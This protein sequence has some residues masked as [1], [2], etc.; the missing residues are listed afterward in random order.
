MFCLSGL[1]GSGVCI[2]CPNSGPPQHLPVVRMTRVL[3]KLPQMTMALMMMLMMVM[4]MTM[5]MM[6]MMMLVVVVVVLVVVVV[7]AVV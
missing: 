3:S 7:V 4:T 1:S 5:T 2:I 6:T